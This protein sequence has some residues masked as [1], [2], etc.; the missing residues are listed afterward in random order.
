[1]VREEMLVNQQKEKKGKDVNNDTGKEEGVE[2]HEIRLGIGVKRVRP[3]DYMSEM[4]VKSIKN[5]WIERMN[6]ESKKEK[7]KVKKVGNKKVKEEKKGQGGEEKSKING[8]SYVQENG[9][10][11][12][13]QRQNDEIQRDPK[14]SAKETDIKGGK[15]DEEKE[16]TDITRDENEDNKENKTERKHHMDKVEGVG[17]EKRNETATETMRSRE[18]A[19]EDTDLRE[20]DQLNEGRERE[21]QIDEINLMDFTEIVVDNT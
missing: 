11:E 12:E 19:I 3:E 2:E 21:I 13:S 6:K 17:E 4:E 7:E 14:E 8:G 5:I 15:K 18:R 20:T 10:E 9:K 16:I 1:M